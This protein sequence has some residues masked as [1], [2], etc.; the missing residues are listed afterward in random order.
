MKILEQSLVGKSAQPNPTCHQGENTQRNIV[1]SFGG[2]LYEQQSQLVSY[3]IIVLFAMCA[4]AGA[5]LQAYLFAKIL[6]ASILPSYCP[7]AIS[8]LW[9]GWFLLLA[10]DCLTFS[11]FILL[12]TWR[13]SSVL[14]IGNSTSRRYYIRYMQGRWGGSWNHKSIHKSRKVYVRCFASGATGGVLGNRD[15]SAFQGNL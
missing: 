11:R 9:C 2:L 7:K 1:D 5:P 15:W 13:T 12:L 8:G 3:V 6:V 10:S 14:C 4:W